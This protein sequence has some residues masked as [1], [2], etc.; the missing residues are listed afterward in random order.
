M[1]EHPTELLSTAEVAARVGKHPKTVERAIRAGR[2]R[3]ARL[4]G[5]EHG[6]YG[7]A[8]E[9]IEE[10]INGAI[11]RAVSRSV[12]VPPMPRPTGRQTHRSLPL[13]P[14]MGRDRRAA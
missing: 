13:T 3:A 1:S 8:P 6:P 14:E 4:S 11:V 9:W 10:W 2:L 5:T 7:V 12:A